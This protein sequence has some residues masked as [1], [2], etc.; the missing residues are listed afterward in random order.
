MKYYT[1]LLGVSMLI[2]S[3]A[4][5]ETITIDALRAQAPKATL[6]VPV[7]AWSKAAEPGRQPLTALQAVTQMCAKRAPVVIIDTFVSDSV[8]PAIDVDG[9]SQEDVEHGDVLDALYQAGGFPIHRVDLGGQRTFP[10]VTEV[11]LQLTNEIASGRL[12]VSAVNLSYTVEV[13]W[14][15]LNTDLTLSPP[16]TPNDALGRRVELS[17]ALA[18]LMDRNNSPDFR[19]MSKAIARLTAIGVPVFVSAGNHT[20]EKVNLLG[21]IPGVIS[22]GALDLRGGKA[23]FSGDSSLV[24]VWAAGEYVFRRVAG[25]LDVNGDDRPDFP[26]AILSGGP[27]VASRFSGRMLSEV[28]GVLPVDPWLVNVDRTSSGG[29]EYLS[30]LMSDGLY[31]VETLAAFFKLSAAKTRTFASRGSYFDKTMRYPFDVDTSGRVIY[32]PARDGSQGQ[33]VIVSG[34]S[35]S[36]PMLCKAARR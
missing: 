25:G 10:H 32:D 7:P 5:A 31:P 1:A 18:Q 21:L 26:A 14:A 12:H 9:D 6:V 13:S 23:P 36:T 33:A 20:P 8:K 2:A 24:E 16:V 34:T 19:A 4:A 35:F 3:S 17:E 30:T 15:S 22:V 27:M 29:V 11:F 28:A